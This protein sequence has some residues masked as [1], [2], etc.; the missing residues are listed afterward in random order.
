[1]QGELFDPTTGQASF[2]WPIETAATGTG[3]ALIGGP[4][5]DHRLVESVE[6]DLASIATGGMAESG[7][8][9]WGASD[10]AAVPGINSPESHPV[11][12]IPLGVSI[13]DAGEVD[14]DALKALVQIDNVTSLTLS[15]TISRLA[16][17]TRIFERANELR[18]EGAGGV[19]LVERLRR[20]FPG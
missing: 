2:A 9:T 12:R 5:S 17:E 10:L 16:D 8:I 19:D 15:Q 13:T 18:Q 1:M 20:E 3:M 4:S 7:L 14:H 11:F 6:R